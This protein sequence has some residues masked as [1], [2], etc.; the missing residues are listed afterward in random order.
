MPMTLNQRNYNL[1]HKIKFSNP[2]IFATHLSRALLFQTMKS[3]RS[4]NLILMYE[5]F[6]QPHSPDLGRTNLILWQTQFSFP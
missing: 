5:R 2:Y 4:N 3:V 1:C 6:T